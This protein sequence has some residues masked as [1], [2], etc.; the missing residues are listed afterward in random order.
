MH[1]FMISTNFWKLKSPMD[2]GNVIDK[3]QAT[4]APGTCPILIGG[5]V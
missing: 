1:M 2:L 3:S 4:S 5:G